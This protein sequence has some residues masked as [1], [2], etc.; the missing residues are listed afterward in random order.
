M[1]FPHTTAHTRLLSDSHL[2]D[3]VPGRL[4][5]RDNPPIDFGSMLLENRRN[6][7]E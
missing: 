4:P 6:K 5:G 7:L 3:L 1:Q 2:C